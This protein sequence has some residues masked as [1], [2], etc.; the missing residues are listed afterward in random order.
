MFRAARDCCGERVV[1]RRRWKEAERREKITILWLIESY[2]KSGR[3]SLF[4]IP[5]RLFDDSHSVVRVTAAKASKSMVLGP[6]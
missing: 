1:V 4:R 5:L 3:F 2:L 6:T